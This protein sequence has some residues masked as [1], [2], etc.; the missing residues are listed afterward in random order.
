M[1]GQGRGFW[2]AA[3]LASK[4]RRSGFLPHFLHILLVHVHITQVLTDFQRLSNFIVNKIGL[5]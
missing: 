2:P 4:R 5:R 1:R 3:A